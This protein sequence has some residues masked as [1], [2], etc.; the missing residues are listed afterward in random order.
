M[1]STAK[2]SP[3]DIAII[4]GGPA[5]LMAAEVLS[6]A[7]LRVD[8]YDG[9]PSVGR[10]FLL[11]GVGGMNI[12][13]SEA[14]PAFLSRYAERAPNLAPLLR[15]FGA[16]ELCTWIH[17]LGIDT[18]V[19]SSGRVFPTDMKAAPLL[20]AWLKRLRDAGVVIHTRHRWLGWNPDGSLRI[21]SPEGD[22]TLHPKATLLALGGGSWSR[23]GSD[24]AWMLALEQR[25]VALAPLQPSNCGFEVEAWSD[26]MISKFAGAPLKNIAMGLNDDVPRLGECVLTATG[27]EGSLVY[28]L[29]ATIREAINQYGSATIH[30]DLLPGRPVDKILQALNKPR[31]S[32]SMAKH[33]HSQLGID[34][35]KAALL[36]ELTPAECFSDPARLAQ[37]IKA[38]PVTLVKPRPLD[39]A[40]S[41]AG[42]VTFEAL[43]ERL[44]L[45][46]V[47]GVFCAGEMLDWEAPTGG[48]LLTACFASGRTA[49]LGVLEWL[50]RQG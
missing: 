38:L 30:L 42:G 35:V 20:R 4:G 48:Y 40:I 25:G 13:H 8:L 27:L 29:S 15:A 50:Q 14:F 12:T 34:G 22:K 39:E 10:K 6:Q 18:F 1:T 3:S 28:A 32:R 49:G 5:G 26:L 7:G 47:P 33:L 19:G 9:M 23:L 24:G 45:K 37:A 41:S 11:A 2:P 43:D 17:G 44:M 31:G 36:R 46:Q 16:D 21:A